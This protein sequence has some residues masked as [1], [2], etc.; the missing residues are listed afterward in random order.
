MF[1]PPSVRSHA[2]RPPEAPFLGVGVGLRPVHF[3]EVLERGPRGELGVDW[4]EV[5][6]ENYMV[7]G[8]RPLRILDQVGSFAPLAMHGVSLSIGSVDPLDTDYLDALAALADRVKPVWISDHLCW[9]GVDSRNLHDL[10]PLPYTEEAVAHVVARVRRVQD[11]LG[12]RI[13][14][15]N[16]S[17]YVAFTADTMSEAE[18]LVAVAEAA[19]CGILLDVNNV[20][21]SAHNHH[22]DADAYIDSI[23]SERVFQIHL[24]GHSEAGA[25]LID[26][27][28]HPVRS[29][30][31]ALFERAVERVG[32]VSTLIE[33][34]DRIPPFETL[35]EEARRARAILD[36]VAAPEAARVAG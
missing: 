35:V 4:F 11:R 2:N 14:L 29:E 5:L 19:D 1:D 30:V 13:A 9:T 31:W 12:R 20:Y 6:S 22:L 16:V 36:R 23:P 15:E 25:L 18:F 7:D 3:P 10:M 32:P 33:W 21:V 34:D 8:G 26:T 24:A 28:D 27:H 17:S